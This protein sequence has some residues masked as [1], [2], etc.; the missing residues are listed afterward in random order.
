MSASTVAQVT[1]DR[2]MQ[3]AWGYAPPLILESAI[4]N[5]IFDALD[6]GPK[7]LDELQGATGTSVRG[8]AAIANTLVGLNFLA[9]DD[10]GRFSLMPESAAFLVQNKPSF[11]GGMILHTSEQLIPKW[12]SL[13]E[14]VKTG[15][16]LTAVNQEEAGGAFF[17]QLV[18]DIFPMSYPAAK[19]LAA[20]L[21]L[22]NGVGA[23][24]VLDLAAGS[25]VWGIAL[26]QS[27]P[28]VKVTAVDWPEV[29][30]LTKKTTARFGVDDRFNFVGGDLLSADFGSGHQIATLGHILHSEGKARSRALLAKT[31]EALASGGTIAIAEFLVNKERTGPLN[32][33]IF[34][35]NMLVN[36]DEGGTWSFEEIGEWLADAGFVNARTLDSPGPSPLI[37]ATKP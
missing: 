11:M 5:G 29:L 35:V 16:P 10:T 27:S 30:P 23:V 1:P 19:T 15:K 24:S 33:L 6:S 22:N 17:E 31:F 20:S 4:R 3:F 7:N 14:I 26:A 25:G 13:N 36:T 32:G 37:L 12:L 28:Q 8:L 2:I 21:N 9:K 18:L 34:A